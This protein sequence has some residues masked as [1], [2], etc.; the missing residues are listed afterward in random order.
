MYYFCIYLNKY[1]NLLNFTINQTIWHNPEKKFT[2]LEP[3][4]F[5]SIVS[6][7]TKKFVYQTSYIVERNDKLIVMNLYYRDASSSFKLEKLPRK[8]APNMPVNLFYE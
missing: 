2:Y 4:G 5:R 3:I 7:N 8:N 1:I 6:L